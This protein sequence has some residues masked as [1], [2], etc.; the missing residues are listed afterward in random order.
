LKAVL[1]REEYPLPEG[2]PAGDAFCAQCQH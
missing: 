1:A 2:Q